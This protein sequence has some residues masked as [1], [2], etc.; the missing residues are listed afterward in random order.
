MR[1]QRITDMPGMTHLWRVNNLFLAGQPAPETLDALKDAGINKVI[2]IRSSGEADFKWEEEGLAERGIEYKHLPIMG[3]KGIESDVCKKISDE[4]NDQDKIVVH[5]A[6]ANRVGAWLIT[7]LVD[8]KGFD[9]ESAV[10]LAMNAGL[11]NPG[12]V[13]QAQNIV[14]G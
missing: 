14:K 9:F 1:S 4:I 3:E 11:S 2:N 6:S 13:G 12:F 5:C 7:Y 10:D 8:Y